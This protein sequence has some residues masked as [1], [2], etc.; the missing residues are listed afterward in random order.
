[1]A[2]LPSL[3]VGAVLAFWNKLQDKKDKAAT[4]RAEA[5]QEESLLNLN[6]T[7]AGAKLSYACAMALKR[8]KANGE[9]ETAVDAYSKAMAEYQCF[10]NAEAM[11]RINEKAI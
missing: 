8:G 3:F 11:E 2:V 5:R 9:V 1:M 10:L 6:L 4:E 7:A